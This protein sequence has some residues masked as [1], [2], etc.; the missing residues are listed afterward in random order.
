MIAAVL[1]KEFSRRLAEHLGPA[2]LAAVVQRNRAESDRRLCHSHDFCDANEIM[3]E[4]GEAVGV[5]VL[6][7]LGVTSLAWALAKRAEFDHTRFSG[8]MI[9]QSDE[10][11]VDDLHKIINLC[12]TPHWTTSRRDR[13]RDLALRIARQLEGGSNG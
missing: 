12:E 1:A 7:R 13:I 5:D 9:E 10:T 11:I 8:W 2:K 3:L 4:A 6:E